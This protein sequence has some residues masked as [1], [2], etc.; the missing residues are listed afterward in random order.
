MSRAQAA[1]AA[2]AILAAAFFI[3]LIF[4]VVDLR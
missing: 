4:G 3:N 1:L 2:L